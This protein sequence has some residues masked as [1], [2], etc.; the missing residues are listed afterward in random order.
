MIIKIITDRIA[1]NFCISHSLFWFFKLSS[2]CTTGNCSL[3]PE[4]KRVC[5]AWYRISLKGFFFYLLGWRKLLKKR[6]WRWAVYPIEEPG[7]FSKGFNPWGPSS[8]SVYLPPQATLLSSNRHFVMKADV[9]E[10]SGNLSS[11]G[12]PLTLFVFSDSVEV[13]YSSWLST[14]LTTLPPGSVAGI[15]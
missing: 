1:F 12:D 14:K 3:V 13:S 9:M 7:H 8:L 4:S 5:Q 11:R 10:L 15:T 6:T 2:F